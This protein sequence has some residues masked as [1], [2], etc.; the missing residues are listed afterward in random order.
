MSSNVC[1]QYNQYYSEIVDPTDTSNILYSKCFNGKQIYS[2][3]HNVNSYKNFKGTDYYRWVNS[4]FKDY[5]FDND[6]FD[7]PG[8]N[9]EAA[10]NNLCRSKEYGLKK[11]QKFAGRIMNTHTEPNSMLIYHGLGSG[12]TQTSIIV[13]EAFKFR[14]TNSSII[15]DRAQAR[16]LIVVPAALLR[17]YYSEIVGKLE[18]NTLKSA[19]GEVWISG[20]R[21]YYTKKDLRGS[22]AKNEQDISNLKQELFGLRSVRNPDYELIDQLENELGRLTTL[23]KQSVNSEKVKVN[24]VYEIISHETFLNTIFKLLS[25]KVERKL[26]R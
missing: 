14:K 6:D 9:A 16:V 10:F 7:D 25:L 5:T 26:S 12:K 3:R 21:Q 15:P 20:D 22:I 13:G 2:T 18:D 17:Q 24:T 19:P 11:Q 4:N 23:N 1:D 8:Y